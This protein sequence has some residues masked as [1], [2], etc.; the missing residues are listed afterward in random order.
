MN[1]FDRFFNTDTDD[2]ARPGRRGGIEVGDVLA[3]DAQ[4]PAACPHL[5]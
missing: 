5:T 1:L 2:D 3:V 4:A